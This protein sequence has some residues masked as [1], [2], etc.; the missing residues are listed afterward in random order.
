MA[1]TSVL[2]AMNNESRG[3]LHSFFGT[4]QQHSHLG[5][6]VNQNHEELPAHNT[7]FD[8]S[9]YSKPEISEQG[10]SSDAIQSGGGEHVSTRPEISHQLDG[11]ADAA[12]DT[13]QSHDTMALKDYGSV[14]ATQWPIS[15]KSVAHPRKKRKLEHVGNG[16]GTKREPEL[17]SNGN[18]QIPP[19]VGPSGQQVALDVIK[20]ADGLKDVDGNEHVDPNTRTP[21][22]KMLKLGKSGKLGS[23]SSFAQT[24][25]DDSPAMP[26]KRGRPRKEKVKET[27]VVIIQYGT[28][29][30]LDNKSTADRIS[31]I[32]AGE[33]RYQRP[34]PPRKSLTV[35]A[36][37]PAKSAHPFFSGKPKSKTTVKKSQSKPEPTNQESPRRTAAATPG[38]IRR[39]MQEMRSM[40]SALPTEPVDVSTKHNS[41]KMETWP[42]LGAT[43]V[44]GDENLVAIAP[45]S[46]LRRRKKKQQTSYL[47]AA[48]TVFSSY[49]PSKILEGYTEGR[50]RTDGFRDPHPRLRVPDRKLLSGPQ[51]LRAASTQLTSG[52]EHLALTALQ[53]SLPSHLTAYDHG[54]GEQLPW[55]QKYAPSRAELV[56][57]P[58]NEAKLLR[59]WMKA[60]T[61]LSTTMVSASGPNKPI[62]AKPKKKRRKKNEEWDDFIVSSGDETDTLGALTELNEPLSQGSKADSGGRSMIRTVLE[63]AQNDAKKTANTV[64]L[65]GPHGCGKTAMVFAAAKELGFQVFEINAGSRRSG[66]D[67][68]ER[69]GDVLGNHIVSHEKADPGNVSADE[70]SS[71]HAAALQKDL[72]SGRQGT[73]SSFFTIGG[74]KLPSKPKKKQ[75]VPAVQT[76]PTSN[77]QQKQ[78]IILLEEVDILFEEDKAFWTTVL[79]VMATSRRPIVMTCTS[80][81]SLPLD[82][83]VLHTVLRL[84]PAPATLAVDYLLLMAAQEG[85]LISRE[86]VTSLYETKRHDL[87]ASI[88]ELQFWCQMGVGDPR[89]GLSWI[90]QRFPE[91]TGV[92][93][94]GDAQRVVSNGSYHAAMGVLPNDHSSLKDDCY[95]EEMLSKAWSDWAVDPR[96]ESHLQL[97]ELPLVISPTPLNQRDRLAALKSMENMADT[98]SALDLLPTADVLSR[99]S[100]SRFSQLG[101]SLSTPLDATTPQISTKSRLS[102]TDYPTFLQ[103]DPVTEPSGLSKQLTITTTFLLSKVH[104]LPLPSSSRLHN[105]IRTPPSPALLP[106][107]ATKFYTAL[108]PLSYP[109]PSTSAPQSS[110]TGGYT[111]LLSPLP[112]IS[113]D[114]APYVRQIAAHD[115]KLEEE[116][117]KLHEVLHGEAQGSQGKMR[118]TRAARRGR[119]W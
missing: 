70:D 4:P 18:T 97:T 86:A 11:I 88:T 38:K 21:P 113:T 35:A 17:V 28:E 24:N 106:L 6:N 116:R 7:S 30:L 105:L 115:I 58:G 26:K 108:D 74:P 65:S 101:C 53:Q 87:R 112:C 27:K 80:E 102:Y 20:G 19:G 69:I 84:S 99:I 51:L 52:V 60:L 67:V 25:M 56:L 33:E 117:R 47:D 68:L 34:P 39:Q 48:D 109:P 3:T 111:F 41:L 92:D 15:S 14:Q 54:R 104:S 50:L 46:T 79:S 95:Y 29:A 36:T 43:H 85:H 1:A 93:E 110:G 114:I 63:G 10:S 98:L 62:E 44:R 9:N 83:L 82:D 13:A 118:R 61:V 31:R 22:K 119:G 78:S 23:P 16:D 89:G 90:F 75:N 76:K 100:S 72:D 49:A 8:Q 91:G 12:N 57:Q 64:L 40:K 71:R 32:M 37:G 45:P 59:D 77:R 107:P 73:M 96:D 81:A 2:V 42:F 5:A 55:T 66:K 94:H 103:A